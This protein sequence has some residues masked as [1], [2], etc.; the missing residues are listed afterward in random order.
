[1][2]TFVCA[3]CGRIYLENSERC[4]H[5]GAETEERPASGRGVVY[6]FSSV[7]MGARGMP[8]PYLLALV[9]LEEGGRILARLADDDESEPSIGDKVVFSGLSDTGP[10]FRV[11]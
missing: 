6:S 10:V 1:M 5:C 2:E 8:T 11:S 4:G 3:G 9:E 7:H